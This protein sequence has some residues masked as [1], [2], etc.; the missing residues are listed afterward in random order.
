M[1]AQL[2]QDLRSDIL[3]QAAFT[4]TIVAYGSAG[5]TARPQ[6]RIN[7][8]ASNQPTFL[9][10]Q[11]LQT[12]S[13]TVNIFADSVQ[14]IDSLTDAFYNRY[15]GFQGELNSNTNVH[16]ITVT[17]VINAVDQQ[18][19]DIYQAILPIDIITT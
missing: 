17:S 10:S 15:H 7:Q 6:I 9:D 5:S 14:D 3:A 1:F 12:T 2:K 16:G 4:N 8:A 19:P 18:D 13:L 11:G